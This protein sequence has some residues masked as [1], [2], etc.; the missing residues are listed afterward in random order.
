M[1]VMVVAT[2]RGQDH[3]APEVT[4]FNLPHVIIL[5]TLQHYCGTLGRTDL[6]SL[7][8]ERT[9]RHIDCVVHVLPDVCFHLD[10]FTLTC[11][12][13][14]SSTY[15]VHVHLCIKQHATVLKA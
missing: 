3:T 2:W 11:E 14:F 13:I 7:S 4:V 9:S 10:M 8:M 12:V 1:F 15:T 6:C 5:T